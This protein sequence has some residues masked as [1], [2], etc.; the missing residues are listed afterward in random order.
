MSSLLG[1]N[2]N[3]STRVTLTENKFSG[4][5]LEIIKEIFSFK[6]LLN[7]NDIHDTS[8]CGKNSLVTMTA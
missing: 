6:V 7:K 1:L 4:I 5:Y 8:M 2:I 3:L